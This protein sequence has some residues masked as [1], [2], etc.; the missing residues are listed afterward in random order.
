MKTE[1]VKERLCCY[2]FFEELGKTQRQR[3]GEEEETKTENGLGGQSKGLKRSL[4]NCLEN[5]Y[6]I[7]WKP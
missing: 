7:A 6:Q 5:W 4:S 2:R 3:S 1:P